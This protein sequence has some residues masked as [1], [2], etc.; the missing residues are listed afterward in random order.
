VPDNES[1]SA[2]FGASAEDILQLAARVAVEGV[3]MPQE[4]TRAVRHFAPDLKRVN[5]ERLRGGLET[6]ITAPHLGAGLQWM[7]EA[8]VLAVVLPE[9]DATV[10]FSQEGGRRHK[11][12]WEHTKQVVRQSRVEPLLRWSALL[13]DIGKVKTR[14]IHENGKVTFHRHAEVGARMFDRVARRFCF[15]KDDKQEI[16]FL[17]YNHLR[18][19]AYSPSWT[20]SA[21][22]RF[23]KEMGPHL[24]RLIELSMADVTS[25][26]PGRKQ[27]AA[28]NVQHLMA[29]ILELREKDAQL[30]PLPPGL[31]NAIMTAFALPPSKQIGELRKMCEQAVEL[32]Q[33]EERQP[34]AYYVQYLLT[35]GI[36]NRPVVSA[37]PLAG[38]GTLQSG[39]SDKKPD[40]AANEPE[41]S[42]AQAACEPEA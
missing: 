30:P 37:E 21:V 32:G 2:G 25:R 35:K 13:H 38:N 19:N 27:A 11:D 39:G 3:S 40:S 20:D 23:D 12:V 4:I 34:A 14:V 24:E 15:P 8:G 1:K 29:R 31:G 10:D 18:A 5:P 17:I 9:L 26:R 42:C 33:L 22:R 41:H 28:R 6:V 36:V 7:H 16:R